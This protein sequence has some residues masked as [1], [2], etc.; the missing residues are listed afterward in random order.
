MILSVL[1]VL[2]L[3]LDGVPA[4]TASEEA[5]LKVTIR[6]ECTLSLIHI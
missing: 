3:E 2:L 5:A 6:C 4:A 1:L